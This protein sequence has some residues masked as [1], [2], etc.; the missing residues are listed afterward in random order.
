MT[1]TLDDDAV[2][3]TASCAAVAVGALVVTLILRRLGW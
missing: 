3:L 2:I 1:P